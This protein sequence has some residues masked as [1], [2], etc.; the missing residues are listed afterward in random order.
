MSS[1][2]KDNALKQDASVDL[3]RLTRAVEDLIGDGR[4]LTSAV[5]DVASAWALTPSDRARL[6]VAVQS[7]VAAPTSVPSWTR[8]AR[9]RVAGR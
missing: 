6:V 2:M 1:Y 4:S 3:D 9:V 5:K 7:R 8:W